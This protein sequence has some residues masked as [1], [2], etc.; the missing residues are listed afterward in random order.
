MF[1]IEGVWAFA[2]A[3]YA[4]LVFVLFL[5]FLALYTARTFTKKI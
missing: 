4:Y 3:D 5:D 1:H 2:G